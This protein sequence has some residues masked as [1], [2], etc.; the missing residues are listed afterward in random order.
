MSIFFLLSILL[1][2]ANGEDEKMAASYARYMVENEIKGVLSSNSID[3]PSYPFGTVE[4]FTDDY[5]NSGNPYLLLATISSSS[6]NLLEDPRGTLSIGVANCSSYDFDGM[7]YDPLACSRVDLV[8]EF[9]L[10]NVT[11]CKLW[12]ICIEIFISKRFHRQEPSSLL[13]STSSRLGLDFVWS[14]YFSILETRHPIRILR[15]WL[16][17]HSLHVSYVKFI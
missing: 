1:F 2:F 13:Q 8:G 6:I 11:I 9:Q 10:L 7:S 4:D 12:K 16:R 17:K 15:R 14:A 5:Q 3:F